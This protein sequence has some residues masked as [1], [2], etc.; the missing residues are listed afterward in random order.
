MIGVTLKI[1]EI[2]FESEN[3]NNESQL[4]NQ[5]IPFNFYWRP[6][7]RSEIFKLKVCTVNGSQTQIGLVSNPFRLSFLKSTFEC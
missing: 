2:I 1:T 3:K 7:K 5:V 6:L 4:S